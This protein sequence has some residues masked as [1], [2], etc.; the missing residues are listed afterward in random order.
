MSLENNIKC[1]YENCQQRYLSEPH[2]W[3]IVEKDE[4]EAGSNL[5]VTLRPLSRE[6]YEQIVEGQTLAGE[7]HCCCLDHAV[8]QAARFCEELM[9]AAGVP[10]DT[11]V[12][13]VPK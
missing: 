10:S 6:E 5:G 4:D 11:S 2:N 3:W 13:E 1:D 8:K 9:G 12:V 7:V